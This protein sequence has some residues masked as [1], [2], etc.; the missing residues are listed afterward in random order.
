MYGKVWK[1]IDW[2]EATIADAEK[3]KNN[4]SV[5]S[6]AKPKGITTLGHS[7]VKFCMFKNEN[8]VTSEKTHRFKPVVEKRFG[9]VKFSS[10]Y[11]K[12]HSHNQLHSNAVIILFFN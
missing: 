9:R 1:Y 12:C 10:D 6:N 7:M 8:R 2:I 3:T 4:C 5:R 11:K